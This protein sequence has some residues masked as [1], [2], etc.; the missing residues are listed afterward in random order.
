MFQSQTLE[1]TLCLEAMT[2]LQGDA[3]LLA[4]L[5]GIA[6]KMLVKFVLVCQ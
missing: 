6:N 4:A 3:T 1:N 2:L 5:N